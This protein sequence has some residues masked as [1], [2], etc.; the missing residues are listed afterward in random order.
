MEKS[1]NI[2]HKLQLT[3]LILAKRYQSWAKRYLRAQWNVPKGKVNYAAYNN[4]ELAT[5]VPKATLRLSFLLNLRY[6]IELA[7]SD[8]NFIKS[9]GL[10]QLNKD[11]LKHVIYLYLDFIVGLH[12]IH[13]TAAII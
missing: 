9:L 10:V 4:F 1:L 5:K 6:S 3:F 11:K 8:I 2:F 13:V 7:G 12:H